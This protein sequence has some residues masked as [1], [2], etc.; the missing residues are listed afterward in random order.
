MQLKP[1]LLR[2]RRVA[3]ILLRA[4]AIAALLALAS[5]VR[6]DA[7]AQIDLYSTLFYEFGGPLEMLVITPRANLR[8]DPV[9]ELT[10]HA[11]Y[12]ADIVSGA[13]VAVVDAPSAEVDAVSSA[14]RL[15]DF[16]H[17]ITGGLEV[18]SNVGSL[19]GSYSYGFENDYRSHSFSLGAR[20]DVFERNT[21][22]DLSY[23]RGFDEVCD[24]FQPDDLEAVQRQ[25]LDSAEGCFADQSMERMAH[26]IDLQTF[27]GSWTQAWAPIFVTQLTLSAQLID[28]FQSNPYRGVWLGRTS[29]QEHHPENRFRYAASLGARLWLEPLSGALQASVRVYR[30]NWDVRSITAEAAYEQSIDGALRFRLRG[31]YYRQGA[32]AFFSDDY[33]TLPRGQYFTGDRE[34]ADMESFMIGLQIA[35]ALTPDAEGSSLGPLESFRLIAKADYIHS[36]YANFHYGNASV[37]NNNSIVATLGL[38][39]VF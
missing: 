4:G 7:G 15:E 30:D 28:G 38:E 22:F 33:A 31:R 26:R 10:L 19:R 24:V 9:E 13:S 39:F 21:T 29:A 11:N 2:I 3:P 16:R 35:W 14:T 34:L 20:T 18:R 1:A 23:A 32:A 5:D 36:E 6:A 12:E 37:P 17:V 25:R 27:Q 8:V